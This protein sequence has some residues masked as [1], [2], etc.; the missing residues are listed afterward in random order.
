[1]AKI[2][3]NRNIAGYAR[4]IVKLLYKYHMLRECRTQKFYNMEKC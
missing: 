1:M 3:Q 4:V 2:W